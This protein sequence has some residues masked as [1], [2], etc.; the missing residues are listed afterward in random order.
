MAIGF[1]NNLI[2]LLTF[3]LISISVTAMVLAN[4][5]IAQL[6]IVKVRFPESFAEEPS[7]IQVS[8]ESQNSARTLWELEF[9]VNGKDIPIDKKALLNGSLEVLLSWIPAKRGWQKI[10]KVSVKSRYPFGLFRAWQR[11][12][13]QE[14]VLVFAARKGTSNWPLGNGGESD[15]S[16]VGV[17][18]EHRE[19]QSSDS[20]RRIDWKVSARRQEVFIKTYEEDEDR[21][22]NFHWV[23]TRGLQETEE[24]ISQLALWI[25]LAYR[26]ELQYSLFVGVHKIPV[27]SG[28]EHYLKCQTLLATIE[29]SDLQ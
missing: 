1:A 27:G 22:L 29:E 17:F 10:P 7:D 12:R 6:K 21:I 8:L 9:R 28:R 13:A 19:Y 15:P 5:N 23:Q 18:K 20:W 2:Y 3:L 26:R 11:Y 4:Q 24:R 14:D 16:S 25:D